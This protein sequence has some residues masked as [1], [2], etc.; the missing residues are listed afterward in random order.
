MEEAQFLLNDTM[1]VAQRT[2]C[3]L[4]RQEATLLGAQ[5]DMQVVR[6]QLDAT[7]NS[8]CTKSSWAA[9]IWSS[10]N[11]SSLLG[12]R[13]DLLPLHEELR[14]DQVPHEVV[15][16]DDD[17]TSLI[18]VKVDRL[19]YM[20]GKI[21]DKL[22]RSNSRILDLTSTS[23]Y[24]EEN[25]GILYA[26]VTNDMS[27]LGRS[28]QNRGLF[29]LKVR[30]PDHE[31]TYLSC[32]VQGKILDCINTDDDHDGGHPFAFYSCEDVP[33]GGLMHVSSGR[34]VGL[35]FLGRP[36]VQALKWSSWE[37]IVLTKNGIFFP[38]RHFGTGAWLQW[39]SGD[40]SYDT[41]EVTRNGERV[42][43]ELEKIPI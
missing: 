5:S 39:V 43:V 22:I 33:L 15:D 14:P 34:W 2:L 26:K 38:A 9:W 11:D 27:N 42:E 7:Y 13:R 23:D 10:V 31:M 8:L 19:H 3:D 12:T 29:H 35:D 18:L 1:E 20:G 6:S 24:V 25:V 32:N 16:E 21:H 40:R 37:A 36:V 17:E 30:H 41:F 28:L 4:D